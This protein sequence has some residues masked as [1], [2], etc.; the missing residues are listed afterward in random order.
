MRIRTVLTFF[1]VVLLT[2]TAFVLSRQ[3]GTAREGL[4][5]ASRYDLSRYRI[6]DPRLIG[7]VE[8]RTVTVGETPSALAVDG[9]GS[10]Y[11][12]AGPKILIFA[13]GGDKASEIPLSAPASALAVSPEG[14]IYAAAGDRIETITAAGGA[15]PWTSLG[16]KAIIT[17]LAAGSDSL[18][19]ADAGNGMVWHFDGAGRL[20]GTFGRR[21]LAAG[22]MGFIVPSPYFDV[23][24]GPGEVLWTANP[25]R[26][27]V[28]RRA[29]DG[30]LIDFW[31]KSTLAAEGFGGC[32]NPSHIALLPDGS[33]VTSEKGLPRVKIYSADGIFEAVVAG[34]ESFRPGTVGLDLAVDGS[35]RIIV[36]DP[37]RKLLRIFVPRSEGEGDGHGT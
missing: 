16:E 33:L 28:E 1:V 10:I 8:S 23:A 34:P 6:T 7:Y 9:S 24:L 22:K 27:R 19:A 31:G 18:Y 26:L 12:A 4:R 5:E 35:G 21:D 14:D 15:R 29:L 30:R 20:K 2:G 25:G 32:C 37:A 13:A 17:S 36:L 11:V 3:S